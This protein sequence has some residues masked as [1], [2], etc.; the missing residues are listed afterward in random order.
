M[1][2]IDNIIED[3]TEAKSQTVVRVSTSAWKDKNGIH[4][5]KEL[6]IS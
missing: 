3:T 4:T 5:K 2:L 6:E 1:F